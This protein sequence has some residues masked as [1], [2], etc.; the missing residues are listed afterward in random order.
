[1][2]ARRKQDDQDRKADL[3]KIHIA[4]K[5]L[6]LA[7]DEYR[8]ILRTV[9]RKDSSKDLDYA[10]RRR[11]LDHFVTCGW[12]PTKP[13]S[14]LAKFPEGRLALHLWGELKKQ[15][16][17]RDGRHQALENFLCKTAGV[18]HIR[19]IPPSDMHR[20]VD[21]LKAWEARPV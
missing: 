12:A 5:D 21:Q 7:E 14:E 9:G 3:A 4:K 16:K 17:V 18:A 19:F 11:V 15:G 8:N 10:G 1:M 6:N 2:T 13:D 20:L